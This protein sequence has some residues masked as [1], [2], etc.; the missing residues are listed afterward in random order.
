QNVVVGNFIGLRADGTTVGNLDAGVAIVSSFNSV[1]GLT[2]PDRNVISGNR[3]AG[4]VMVGE[5][6]KFNIVQGNFVGTDPTGKHPAGNA[7]GIDINKA[8]DNLIGATDPGAGNIISG[9]LGNGIDVHAGDTGIP[10][11]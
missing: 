6:A 4:V 5:D 8:S 10:A 11:P 7:V 3:S 9:N 2:P 1:G